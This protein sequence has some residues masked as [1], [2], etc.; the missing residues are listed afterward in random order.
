MASLLY[1]GRHSARVV[2]PM[3]ARRTGQCIERKADL[4]VVEVRIGFQDLIL[5]F[6]RGNPGIKRDRR[7]H[8]E[9][10][11]IVG[12]VANEIDAAGRSKN[13]RARTEHFLES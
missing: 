12:V 8:H 11:V 3:L 6:V 5:T 4:L 13:T 7:G 1:E 2:A 10:V 9:A